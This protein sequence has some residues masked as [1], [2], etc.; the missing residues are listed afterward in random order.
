MKKNGPAGRF[1]TCGAAPKLNC[2]YVGEIPPYGSL[3][4]QIPVRALDEEEAAKNKAEAKTEDIEAF[5]GGNNEVQVEGA[6]VVTQPVSQKISASTSE[7]PF[8]VERYELN[9]EEEDG[10]TDVQAGS[11]PFQ[12]STTLEL[13]EIYRPNYAHLPNES[14][15]AETRARCVDPMFHVQL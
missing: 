2:T 9:P 1:M 6:N 5:H 11:H 7:T 10:T 12:L 13:N 3:Q 4:I 8:G 14:P 15:G